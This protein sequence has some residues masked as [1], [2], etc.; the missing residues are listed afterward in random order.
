MFTDS[1]TL[2]LSAGKGGNGVVAWRREKYIPKGGPCGGNGGRGGSV[3]VKA[4]AQIFA[5][6]WYRNRRSLKAEDGRAGGS[7]QMQGRQ[8]CDL[9]LTVPCGTLLKNAETGDVIMDFTEDGQSLIL[10]KGGKGGL[11]NEFFKSPT[12]RAPNRCTLGKPGESI[13]VDLELKIIA[14]VG[15]VGFPN[16]GKSTLIST[17][18]SV[19]VKTAAYPFTTLKPNLGFITF[20]DQSRIYIADIP[21]IIEGAHNNRGLGFEFLRHIERTKLLLIVLDASGIDGRTPYDDLCVLRQELGK[22]KTDLLTRPSL[23][24]LNKC[25]TEESKAHLEDFYQRYDGDRSILSEISA[26]AYQGT[27]SLTKTIRN[28]VREITP[29]VL[30]NLDSWSS[31]LDDSSDEF[32]DDSFDESNDDSSD[33]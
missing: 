5:L 9:V 19:K 8:G 16:A 22:Y 1:V 6:D 20:E 30:Q 10:C 11:G 26:V 14:D 33:E 24:V 12:N 23:I 28:K 29:I 27:E 7:R 2:E 3:L 32:N 13:K 17:L 4:D 15:L 21:G 18:A 25:D 31:E